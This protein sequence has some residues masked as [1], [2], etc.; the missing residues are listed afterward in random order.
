MVLTVGK[1]IS[2][3]NKDGEKKLQQQHVSKRKA[4]KNSLLSRNK[5]GALFVCSRP[6]FYAHIFELEGGLACPI[7]AIRE[8]KLWE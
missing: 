1:A 5:R 6:F 3:S 2:A 4:N 7:G 8:E